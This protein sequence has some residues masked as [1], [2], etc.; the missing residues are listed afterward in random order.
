MKKIL[1]TLAVSGLSAAAFAQG[2]INWTGAAGYVVAQTNGTTYSSFE[3]STGA[4][5][6]AGTVGNTMVNNA[7]G[8][9]AL[10]YSG[11]Y[12]ELLTSATA[13]A[14]PT[15]P[16]GFS[17]WADT[18][19][20]ATNTSNVNTPGRLLQQGASTL[21]AVNNWPAGNSQAI[22]LVGWSANMGSSW[23][24]VLNE[25]QNWGNF[26]GLYGD[27]TANAAYFGVSA[28]GSGVQ[29]VASTGTGNQVL[30]TG[31]GEVYN[32]GT[33]PMQLNELATTVP[34]PATFALAAIGGASLLLFRRRK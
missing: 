5:A 10:G 17:T 34:E 1:A 29:S 26:Q 15:T 9:A 22:I 7:A 30:G 25:L 18:G 33:S 28:F 19:L 8:S 27:N 21:A 4:A 11:Y 6:L 31:T 14:A 3:P 2:Y 32:P 24:T 23:A 16:G 20:G 12:F 13:S